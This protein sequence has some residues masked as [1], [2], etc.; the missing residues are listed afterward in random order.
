MKEDIFIGPQIKSL[1]K[2]KIFE[3]TMISSEKEAW[4]AFKKV[5]LRFLGQKKISNIRIGEKYSINSKN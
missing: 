2:D 4:V 3:K 1:I 5:I